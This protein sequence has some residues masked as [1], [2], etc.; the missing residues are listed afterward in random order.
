MAGNVAEWVAEGQ[1]RGGSALVSGDGRCSRPLKLTADRPLDDA[2]FRCC[3][4]ASP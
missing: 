3:A 1:L 4:D 2:G